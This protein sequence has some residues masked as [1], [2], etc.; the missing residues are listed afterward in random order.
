MV[1]ATWRVGLLGWKE[2]YD[3]ATWEPV[4][5]IFKIF[6]LKLAVD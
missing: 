2:G 3:L 1:D 5:C 4:H 6:L